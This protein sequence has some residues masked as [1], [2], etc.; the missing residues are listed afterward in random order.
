V[1]FDGDAIFGVVD[2]SGRSLAAQC[3]ADQIVRRASELGARSKYA[4]C[5]QSILGRATRKHEEFD[6]CEWADR[7]NIYVTVAGETL[8]SKAGHECFLQQ[9]RNHQW[10]AAGY[11]A[12]G[13]EFLAELD[14]SFVLALWEPVN[15]RLTL[16]TD[17]RSDA[18]L[19][20][21][22]E[23]SQFLF[24]SWLGLL[25]GPTV[26][27][28]RGAVQEFLR[29]LYVAPPRTICKGFNR[30]EPGHYLEVSRGHIE[31]HKL[32]CAEK[33]KSEAARANGISAEDALD[34][35]QDV[36]ENAI[37]RRIG[38]RRVGV[39]LSSGVD[40]STL[41]AGCQKT[42]PG[43]VEAFT[44]GFENGELD[45]TS[46]ARGYANHLNVRHTVLNFTVRDY[47]QA[48]DEMAGGF[49]QPFADPAGLPLILGSH[50][51]KE[52]VDVLT[53][54]TGGDD[55]FGAPIPRHLWFI[56]KISSKISPV[57]RSQIATTLKHSQFAGLS[58]RASLF[59]FEEPEELFITWAGWSKRELEE[60]LGEPVRLDQSGFYRMFR[61]N[62]H[63][64][65]QGLYDALGIFPPD[66]SRF[67]AAALANIAIELPYHD[68]DLFSY[69]A[70]LPISLR[71]HHGV[72]KLLLKQ[73][74]ARY[75]PKELRLA[76]KRYFN[77]PL[78]AVL[79][80]NNFEIIRTYL[81]RDV[82]IR[83]GL[84]DYE[85]AR[86]WVERYLAG[87]QD[88]MFKVWALLVLHAWLE[89]RR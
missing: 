79:A 67:E 52:R 14:G 65:E 86:T 83:H 43:N 36:F 63:L 57:L 24:S 27:I 25:A 11:T 62:R 75:F 7:T 69:V 88:L 12:R 19:Y 6:P 68:L 71:M 41:L 84:V 53:G 5:G 80:G 18:H 50:A 35:F 22:K 51:A 9:S 1:L 44:I 76:K 8:S 48:F 34:E 15:H 10:I 58:S 56:L 66:D 28:D 49:E 45:E 59:D 16:M 70:G 39:F 26:D 82:V 61:D 87:A 21:R 77:L 32:R 74:C 20:F 72:S 31:T 42:N 54:G 81:A 85:R 89:S 37:L 38:N 73:L 23:K 60:L 46:A 30:L 29:F 78:Q 47:R 64:G 40:S 3:Q 55:L 17:R 13:S 33:E 4:A 2:F